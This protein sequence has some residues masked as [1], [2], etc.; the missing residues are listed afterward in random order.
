MCNLI[1]TH[2]HTHTHTHTNTHTHKYRY[3][4]IVKE[5]RDVEKGGDP[6]GRK[7]KRR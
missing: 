4:Y 2:T 6:G 1:N 3:R 7:K 5:R